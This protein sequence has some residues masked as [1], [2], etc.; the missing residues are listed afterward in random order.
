MGL[1]KG[2]SGTEYLSNYTI[3]AVVVIIAI[4]ALAY[5]G[6]FNFN[7]PEICVFQK[8]LGCESQYLKQGQDYATVKLMN[9]FEDAIVVMGVICSAE[10]INPA[11]ALPTGRGWNDPLPAESPLGNTYPSVNGQQI[12][13]ASN[14][15]VLSQES[16]ELKVVCYAENGNFLGS[17]SSTDRFKGIAFVRYRLNSSP[18]VPGS[19]FIHVIQ[20]NLQGKPN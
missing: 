10:P 18:N 13:A 7:Q 19:S 12:T 20:G 15:V 17:L 16:F 2:Q 8:G 9:Q 6:V 5:L 4:G 3:A 11:N 1:L 14:P